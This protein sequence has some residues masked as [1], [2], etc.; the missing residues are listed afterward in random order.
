[1]KGRTGT[2]SP[3]R[4]MSVKDP[5]P[6]VVHMKRVLDL[7]RSPIGTSVL[8]KAILMWFLVSKERKSDAGVQAKAKCGLPTVS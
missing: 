1:M 4:N 6:T 2:I 8:Q 7:H 5:I 3:Y